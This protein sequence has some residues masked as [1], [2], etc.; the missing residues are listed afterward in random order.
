MVRRSDLDQ[1]DNA[2]HFKTNATRRRH[3]LFIPDRRQISLRQPACL[4]SSQ[5]VAGIWPPRNPRDVAV[6]Q[7][8]R[9][10]S[11]S[12]WTISLSYFCYANNSSHRGCPCSQ[13]SKQMW[14][15]IWPFG[16]GCVRLA[17]QENAWC[18]CLSLMH[19]RRPRKLQ[20]MQVPLQHSNERLPERDDLVIQ[21]L[22]WSHNPVENFCADND[23]G[24]LDGARQLY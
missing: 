22:W 24:C 18:G 7:K 19:A 1:F 20:F 17:C 21:S 15:V 12:V 4:K 3:H 13:W 11:R 9:L 14:S 6:K 23:D 10:A 5:L 16:G 2:S 8:H